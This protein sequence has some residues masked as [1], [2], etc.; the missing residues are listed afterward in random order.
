MDGMDVWA[1]SARAL[2]SQKIIYSAPPQR[3]SAKNEIPNSAAWSFSLP[4]RFEE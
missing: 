1:E 4:K 2:G 3:L